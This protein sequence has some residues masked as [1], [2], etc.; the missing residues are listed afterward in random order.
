VTG[1]GGVPSNATAVTGN[2]TVTGQTNGWAVFLGP[3]PTP[4]PTS[5]TI[6]FTAGEVRANGV[7]VALSNTGTLSA[8]YISSVGNTTDLVFDVTGYFT[9]ENVGAT[10]TALTPARLL[11]TRSGIGSSGR[12]AAGV[13]RTF[14]VA[15]RGGVPANAT[16]VTGN[17]TVTD[18]TMGWAV[19]LGPDP[20]P[21]PSTSTVNFTAGEVRANGVT[22]ALSSSGSLSATYLSTAGQTTNLVFD[23]TGYFTPDDSGAKFVP[24]SPARILDTR[25]GN[26]L[27]GPFVAGKART[28]NV[29]GAGGVPTSAIGVTGNLT[30]TD[31]TQ[32]WAVFL[33]PNP[34][35]SP[36]TST[37]NF[38]V[39]QVIANGVTV[40]LGSGGTLSA[41]YLS[42]TGQT[43]SLVFDVTGCFAP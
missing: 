29:T 9:P 15:G 30:V 6:N 39:G 31:Q 25:V 1:R 34:T 27:N 42:T 16:A 38:S 32:A 35:S 13:P 36:T 20:S 5:S 12:L 3:D 19:F 10:Y 8:T 17:L 37:V 40:A 24:V 18:Q 43:T 11:D 28:F 41:T 4:S 7:T 22:V 23:V 21:S 33:G 26:G 14:Q 2:L